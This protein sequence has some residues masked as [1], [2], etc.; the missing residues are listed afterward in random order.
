MAAEKAKPKPTCFIIMPITTPPHFRDQYRDGEDHFEHVLECLFVPGVEKAGYEAIRPAAEGSDVI[1]AEII[2]NLEEADMVL[3]DISCLN[4]NVFFELGVRTSLNKPVCLVRDGLTP[5]IPFDTGVLNHAP[6]K[7]S[8]ETWEIAHEIESIAKHLKKAGTRSKGANT[9][10]QVFG[11]KTK[12]EPYENDDGPE[13]KLDYLTMRLEDIAVAIERREDKKWTSKGLYGASPTLAS[14]HADVVAELIRSET[15]GHA[16][17]VDC[18]VMSD[19]RLVVRYAGEMNADAANNIARDLARVHSLKVAEFAK[20]M[21]AT[22]R[23]MFTPQEE[24]SAVRP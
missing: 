8:L 4:A 3:C 2:R 22:Y 20:G 10:W 1:H 5:K 9:L 15:G 13:S 24:G 14:P 19:G 16:H 11:M 18:Q 6:Y 17:F 23:H 21:G 12:A 7:E